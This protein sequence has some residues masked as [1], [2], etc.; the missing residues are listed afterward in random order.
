MSI[1]L[2]G[3]GARSGKSAF[4]LRMAQ[5]QGARRLFVATAEAGDGETR[6]HIGRHRDERGDGFVTVEEPLDFARVLREAAGA[7]DVVLVDCLTL[8]MSNLLLR[9]ESEASI[10]ARADDLLAAAG[11]LGRPVILVTNEVGLGL[12][13]ETP[14]GRAFRDV[15]G[16]VHQL[17]AARATEVYMAFLRLIL[18]LVPGPVEAVI[19]G[20]METPA[21]SERAP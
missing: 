20:R 11:A 21:T 18:R 19:E 16:R 14:L 5:A 6:T 17:A 4:A 1:M 12:V 9:D 2:V 8:W 3:G 15:R 7:F 13:L 10:L